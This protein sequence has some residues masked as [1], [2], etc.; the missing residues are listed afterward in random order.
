MWGHPAAPSPVHP[1]WLCCLGEWPTQLSHT[2]Q[3][4]AGD[5]PGGGWTPLSQAGHTCHSSWF[6]IPKS[7]KP[8]LFCQAREPLALTVGLSFTE[9]EIKIVAKQPGGELQGIP[10]GLR[11]ARLCRPQLGWECSIAGVNQK[12]LQTHFSVERVMVQKVGEPGA[13]KQTLGKPWFVV[14]MGTLKA[15]VLGGERAQHCGSTLWL[16]CCQAWGGPCSPPVQSTHPEPG[17][18]WVRP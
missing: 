17:W 14:V 16:G 13:V 4:L 2:L 6:K 5:P 18:G 8:A 12:S 9:L 11:Q 7:C 15:P 10:G 3:Q 1:L